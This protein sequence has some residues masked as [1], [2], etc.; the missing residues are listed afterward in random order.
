KPEQRWPGHIYFHGN[1]SP[2][3]SLP[4]KALEVARGNLINGRRVGDD[5][6]AKILATFH[7]PKLPGDFFCALE[8]S[9]R[10]AERVPPRT[11][12]K[13]FKRVRGPTSCVQ[14]A[15]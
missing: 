2:A 10:F 15:F 8:K 6:V 12:P 7:T 9:R 3:N 11:P 4:K 1:S 5:D 14:W 13:I